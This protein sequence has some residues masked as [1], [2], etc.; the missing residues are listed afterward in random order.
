MHITAGL[1]VAIREFP[2][3]TGHADYMLYADA[4]AIGVVEAKPKGFLVD[5]NNLGKQTLNEFQQFLSPVNGY[6]CSIARPLS[7]A[8]AQVGQ[9]SLGRPLQ[10]RPQ[11]LR[12]Q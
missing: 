3:S 6:K 12:I 2:L 4:K 11:I 7:R 10:I 5:R 8:T 1:G 9:R